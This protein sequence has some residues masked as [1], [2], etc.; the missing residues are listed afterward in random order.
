MRYFEKWF[1]SLLGQPSLTLKKP[2]HING[3]CKKHLGPRL[4]YAIIELQV[5]PSDVFALEF[6]KEILALNEESKNLVDSAIYGILDIIMVAKSLPLKNI[7]INIIH[8]DIHPIDSNK[9]A[10]RKAG[11][12]A[13]QKM[14]NAL[15][16]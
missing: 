13:G 15:C 1:E 5:E 7:K 3:I 11:R 8:V 12:D 4:E 2:L 14:I 6:S 10:F 9:A 16:I